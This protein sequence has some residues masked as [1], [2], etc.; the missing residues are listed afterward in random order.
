MPVGRGVSGAG[1][2]ML[3]LITGKR[4]I[5]GNNVYNMKSLGHIEAV[6]WKKKTD[7]IIAHSTSYGSL[8]M[9]HS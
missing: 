4:G 7:N 2:S 5:D 6:S 8:R 3:G 9:G 1:T